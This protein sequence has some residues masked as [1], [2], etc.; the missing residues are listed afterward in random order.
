MF[1]LRLNRKPD[2]FT[3]TR[4]KAGICDERLPEVT[5]L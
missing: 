4:F 3:F 2:V 1:S 5:R